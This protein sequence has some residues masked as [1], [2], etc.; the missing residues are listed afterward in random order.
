[1]WIRT[2]LRRLTS[3]YTIEKV[4]EGYGV[5]ALGHQG[6]G[7]GFADPDNQRK[8]LRTLIYVLAEKARQ[9]GKNFA[10]LNLILDIPPGLQEYMMNYAIEAGFNPKNVFSYYEWD[11][12]KLGPEKIREREDRLHEKGAYN[13]YKEFQS[14]AKKPKFTPGTEEYKRQFGFLS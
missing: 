9:E 4:G 10:T 5:R 12:Q 8:A 2:A 3:A 13:G 11:M 1:M 6:L 14:L 7:M